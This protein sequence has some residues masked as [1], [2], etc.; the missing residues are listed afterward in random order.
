V[1]PDVSPN[2]F[3]HEYEDA[4]KNSLDT[5]NT[6]EMSKKYSRLPVSDFSTTSMTV[7]HIGKYTTSD[8]ELYNI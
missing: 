8:G 4:I 2:G 6:K 3:L 5:I 7:L 1:N